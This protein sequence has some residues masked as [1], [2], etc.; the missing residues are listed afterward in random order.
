VRGGAGPHSGRS[1]ST[2]SPEPRRAGTRPDLSTPSACSRR[3]FRYADPA[4]RVRTGRSVGVTIRR[5]APLRVGSPPG[6]V[7]AALAG[8]R[9]PGPLRRSGA[10]RYPGS[11]WAA[12]MRDNA[13]KAIQPRHTRQRLGP[14]SP[15]E[16][17]DQ[18]RAIRMRRALGFHEVR[19]CAHP[20]PAGMRRIPHRGGRLPAA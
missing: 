3:G 8:R 13:D 11:S 19:V 4:Q 2:G 1:A 17:C 14:E 5:P 16:I 12:R 10:R 7:A 15:D 18:G 20:A 9:R 6:L